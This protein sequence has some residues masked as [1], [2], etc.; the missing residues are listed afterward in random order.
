MPYYRAVGDIPRKRHTQFRKSDGGLYREELM[1]IEGFSSDS[2]L[3]YHH[4]SPCDVVD[5]QPWDLTEQTRPNY[6]L[7]PRLLQTHKLDAGGDPVTGRRLLAVNPDVRVS[8]V[9]ADKPSP[10]YRNAIGD[11]LY[12]VESGSGRCETVFGVLE[13]GTGDFVVM[14]TSATHRWVPTGDQPLRLL[15]VES[16]GTIRAPKRYVSERGQF[17][18]HAP[19]CERDLRAPTKPHIVE[20][21][22]VDVLVRHRAGGTRY[23]YANHPFDVVGWDGSLYPHVFNVSDFEPITGRIHQPP[24]TFQAFEGPHFVICAFVPHKVEY[25]PDAVIVPYNHA[26]VDSDELMFHPLAAPGGRDGH[27]VT[28]GAITWHPAGFIHGPHTGELEGAVKAYNRGLVEIKS[29]HA[30]M[31]DTFRPL[32]VGEGALACD[33]PDYLSSWRGA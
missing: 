19:Y 10:L 6:P 22:D 8:Y 26:N 23:T 32:E 20:E 1:G 12:Y 25:H 3:L 15:I 11:E 7:M 13:V 5:V 21:H 18:E 31:V 28:E 17:L 30:V 16:T 33:V 4:H 24:P 9:A 27:G 14:P 29:L 2:A